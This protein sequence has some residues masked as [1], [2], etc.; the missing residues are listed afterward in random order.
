MTCYYTNCIHN[1]CNYYGTCPEDYSTLTYSSLYTSC[2]YYYGTNVGAIAGGV[3][4]GVIVA[5]I[6]V[7]VICYCYRKRQS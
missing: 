6:V 5:I 2:Y 4:A 3:V 1:C 7:V